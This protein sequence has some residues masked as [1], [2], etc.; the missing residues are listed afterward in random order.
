W[1]R[2]GSDTSEELQAIEREIGP[3][4]SQHRA[5]QLTDP[6]LFAR[7]EAVVA[8]P[9]ALTSE[10]ARVLDLVQQ[11]HARAVAKLDDA[12]RARMQT[13]MGRLSE[14]GTA[15]SQNVLKDEAS[16][17]LELGED[18]LAGLPESFIA[19]ARSDAAARGKPGHVVTLA[20]SSVEPF[21]TF[22]S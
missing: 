15:F 6:R 5:R 14:L 1:N 4:L 20:R 7:I 11:M 18:D 8:S 3:R 17:T 10:Q 22:S 9:G 19:A 21:L 13:I 16:W 12:G 2:G